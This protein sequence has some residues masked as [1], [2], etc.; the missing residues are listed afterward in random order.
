MPERFPS[1]AHLDQ[2]PLSDAALHESERLMTDVIERLVKKVE[3]GKLIAG[4]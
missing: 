3:E 2:R 4:S 1:T